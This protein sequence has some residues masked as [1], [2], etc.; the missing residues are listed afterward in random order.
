MTDLSKIGGRG[1]LKPKS[2]DEP[3]W[4]RL[5]PRVFV[6]YRP[7]RSDGAGTWFARAYCC[8]GRKYLRKALGSFSSLSGHDVFAAA[9]RES[10][11][12]A[13]EVESGGVLP[14]TMVT[15]RDA[16]D[17]YLLAKPSPIAAGVFRRH[18]FADPI[19]RVRLD[20]LRRRH[21][22]DW[23]QRLEAAPAL[24]SRSKRG[25]EVTK[26]RSASTVNRDMVPLRAALNRVLAPGKPATDAAWQEALKPIAG[27]GR[28]RTLYLSKAE[29][30]ALIN[31]LQPDARPFFKA[32]CILPVRPG[33]LSALKV[34]D[35]DNLTRTLTIG[36]DKKVPSRQFT[37]PANTAEF[38][39]ELSKGKPQESLI[40]ERADGAQW[41]KDKWKYPVK[42]AAAA[43]GL[44]ANTT[45]YSLRH[46]VI[47]D[48]VMSG[49]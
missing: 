25:V 5:R 36:T 42:E 9:K 23:R 40:F 45:A 8:E 21:L 34:K 32:L 12:W 1:K 26:V 31:N 47:T 3:H 10:E 6:G 28:R 15:V 37:I 11:R 27:A 22:N 39:G 30:L 49:D 20:R 43:A 18:V 7:S 46:S 29:R 13:E 2:G 4:Q 48:L 14:A 16:C 35:L 44:S 33:A 38:L 41:C 19:A 24:V 17:A